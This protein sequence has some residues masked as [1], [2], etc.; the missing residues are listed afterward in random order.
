MRKFIS[1]VSLLASVLGFSVIA[2][3]AQAAPAAPSILQV[4][5]TRPL[6]AGGQNIILYGKN[7]NV[8]TAVII[9]KT[10]AAIVSKSS[11]TLVFISPPHAEGRVN[12]SLKHGAKTYVLRDALRY[13]YSPYAPLAPLPFIPETLRAG[14]TV[15]LA[16]FDSNWKVTV[17]TTSTRICSVTGLVVKALRR[18]ECALLID[19]DVPYT[20]RNFRSREALYFITV[21]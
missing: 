7:L 14:R 15:S 13:K 1:V 3:P 11:T 17:T 12:I 6:P 19:I 8:V 21:N 5:N 18:G 9:D 10:Q 20:D 4:S 16:P 2:S